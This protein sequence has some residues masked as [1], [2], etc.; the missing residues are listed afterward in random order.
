METSVSPNAERLA[1]RSGQTRPATKKGL[2]SIHVTQVRKKGLSS[3]TEIPPEV[4]EALDLHT[5][6]YLAWVVMDGKVY[7]EK[8]YMWAG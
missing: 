2:S 3:I 6:S 1:E 8:A 4:L 7:V 5:D